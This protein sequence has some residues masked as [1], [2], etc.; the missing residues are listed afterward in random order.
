[1]K[2]IGK[3]LRCMPVLICLTLLIML[4]PSHAVMNDYCINPPFIVGGVVPNLLMMFDNSSS[5]FDLNYVDKGGA[6]RPSYYCYDQTYRTNACS[7]TTAT[8]C[9]SSSE[10]PTGQTCKNAYA[11]VFE[12][13]KF[14][15]YNF[16]IA[17]KNFEEIAAFPPA[18]CSSY[19]VANTLC[20]TIAG[21]AVT[22]FAAKG[23]YLNWLSASKFDNQ[24]KILTG[25]KYV[26]KVCA[27]H[28]TVAC[29]TDGDCI[30]GDNCPE[31]PSGGET[32]LDVNNFLQSESRGCVGRK[33]VKEP[34]TADFQEFTPANADSNSDGRDDNDPNIGLG[35]TFG[36][37]GPD[38]PF[39]RTALSLGGQTYID[40]FLGDYSQ[41]KCDDAIKLLE[42]PNAQKNDT[43]TAIEKCLGYAATNKKYCTLDQTLQCNQDTDCLV[44]P[45]TYT[46]SCTLGAGTCGLLNNGVCGVTTAGTCTAKN[47]TCSNSK[48][49]IGG[50][51]A[52]AGCNNNNACNSGV[53]SKTC[54]GGGADSKDGYA[55]NNNNACLYSVCTAG[56]M[57]LDCTSDATV[58][59]AK[60]CTNNTNGGIKLGASCTVNADCN[61]GTCTTANTK[62]GLD[63]YS[64]TQCSD[65]K[66][67]AGSAFNPNGYCESNFDCSTNKG[68]CLAPVTTQIKS[69]FAQSMHSCYQYTKKGQDI[70]TNEVQQISNP[71]GCNQMYAQYM[72]C[73]GGTNHEKQC[74]GNAGDCP[75]GT[76]IKGPDAIVPGSPV[77]VC[78]TQ[79]TGYCA[80]TNDNW[81]NTIWMPRGY[82]SADECI[83]AKYREYC[84]ALEVPPV[85]DPTDAPSASTDYQNLPAIINDIGLDAQLDLIGTL[86]VQLKK[87][88][89]P[90]GLLN[91]YSGKIRFGA[92]T[93]NSNG[94]AAECGI[95]VCSNNYTTTCSTNSDCAGTAICVDPVPCPKKC[96][97]TT[98]LACTIKPDCPPGEE[99]IATT[100]GV[101]LDNQ[102]GALIKH[103]I[104]AN[105]YCE[106]A[107]STSC[108]KD[109]DCPGTEKCISAGNHNYGLISTTDRIR[110]STWTPFT[111]AFYNAI[112]YY[113]R[114]N[115][116]SV[117]PGTSRTALRLNTG[118]FLENKNPS[119]YYCQKNNILLIT[120]GS[121]TADL[122]T[123]TVTLATR[124]VSPADRA[125]AGQVGICGNYKGSM[126]LD[127]VAWVAKH[128]DI[129]TFSPT[130]TD[131]KP[132]SAL[133]NS[134][135]I[136]TYVVFTGADNGLTGECNSFT[137]MNQTAA[138]GG[139]TS[140]KMAEDPEKL[141]NALKESFQTIASGAGS[142][143]AAS[144]LASGE[145]SG[146]NLIQALFYTT[147][148]T[149]GTTLIDPPIK[150]T[151]T[152]KNLWYYID[153][154]IGNSTIREDNAAP[155][156]YTLN[157]NK[158]KIVNFRFTGDKTVVDLYADA[159]GD[160]VKDS[161]TPSPADVP[162]EDVSSLWEAGAL[163]WNRTA[164]DRKI[165]TYDGTSL[166]ELPNTISV[167]SPLIS[168]LQAVNADEATAIAKYVK[169]EDVKVCNNSKKICTVLGDCGGTDTS[170]DAYRS[171]TV[172][173]KVWKLGDIINSTPRIA[174]WTPQNLYHKSYLDGEYRKFIES[175]D[176]G[177]RG[178]VFTGAND[179]MF[180]AFYLGQLEL[181]SEKF[182]KATLA[183]PY[184]IGIGKELWAYIPR[185][186][187]PYLRYLADKEY[188]HIY[189]AD[190]TPYIFD[191]SINSPA[192]CGGNYWDCPKQTKCGANKDCTTVINTLDM[193]NTSWRTVIIGSMRLGG[194][195][196]DPASPST[197]GVK[198][199]LAGEGFSSYF[200]LDITDNLAHPDDPSG[201]P[202]VLLWEFSD[203]S[204]GFS[205]T[206]PAVLRVAPKIGDTD[207]SGTVDGQDNADNNKN[208]RFYVVIGSGP[209]GPID[210]NQFRSYS[211]QPLKLFV[212][213][214]KTGA[215]LRTFNETDFGIKNAFAGSLVN[216][217]VDLDQNNP[218]YA[219]FY[220]D[221]AIYFGYT[222]AE[223]DP[224]TASTKWNR[225]GIMRLFTKH[226]L[227]PNLWVVSKVMND[228]LG[229]ASKDDIV[230]PVTAAVNRLQ[231]YTK[232]T[233]R[234]FFG[235]GRYS[236]KISSDI[237]D[238][239]PKDSSN[240]DIPRRLFGVIEPCFDTISGAIDFTCSSTVSIGSLSE[241]ANA[242]G[243]SDADGWYINLDICTKENPA[244]HI[245][246]NV[247]CTSTDEGVYKAERSVTDIAA[248]PMGAVFFTTTK[249]SAD[250]CAFGGGT[251]LWAVQYDTGGEVKSGV[252]RGKAIV[253]VSTGEI[254]EVDLKVAFTEKG[255]RRTDVIPGVPPAGPPPGLIVPPQPTNKVI[256]IRER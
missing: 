72:T 236:Y 51:N 145:G 118:D 39:N 186:A 154:F 179:G 127:D 84:G 99:C 188:C 183:D 147:R 80:D 56:N 228:P 222:K 153:P 3:F 229:A 23:N 224:L 161:A 191:A 82:A 7:T 11:G 13:N 81:Q 144:V 21:S 158:D 169:G 34:N 243:T 41:M 135:M 90:T 198:T 97:L 163:L 252:L 211:D 100:K 4:S 96:S 175:D 75:G 212:L 201:H 250:V 112:G 66:C 210:T 207:L 71:S 94:T 190:A 40:V 238:D 165:C 237:D 32:C 156:D 220:Q 17:K 70:G 120:D 231:N 143:T 219:G 134:E 213:D 217:M 106:A 247:A 92:M 256:H 239:N 111:E 157:I 113:A 200:A 126:N 16:D 203:P 146:A 107:T 193:A 139:T 86:V 215:L 140:A 12:V 131:P 248:T 54:T 185:N 151:G 22:A 232:K 189:Y 101:Y 95:K 246:T 178:L 225:G 119:Q 122:Q 251:H 133:K 36:V 129:K 170:C 43:Q 245:T 235:S 78:S 172:D 182:K 205:T 87:D 52:G 20:A 138:N 226:E 168:L 27:F 197:L 255:G 15:N 67:T 65:S 30:G 8:K 253:Q 88:T 167:G 35:I 130:S 38:H 152:L 110:A 187:L 199:P 14:Y 85:V 132:A 208:G 50:T 230:G 44:P 227:D 28:P 37:K 48:S 192:G 60:T 159:N 249:P 91:D 137:M 160:G 218:S 63:C 2:T 194:G 76:C 174:S 26:D 115:A 204:L 209:T 123:D 117:S 155:K 49:C 25:G 162:F 24:K 108:L 58:C 180:H 242:L 149:F 121:S 195:C 173:S 1:M 177:K 128:R 19:L 93:F 77:L 73:N 62:F 9:A 103:Y 214:L 181:F 6:T 109:S 223:E 244:T 233:L 221:D 166:I 142:G 114:T 98:S 102:D 254:R 164:S 141:Y 83:K 53:C 61:T 47:G 33:F 31:C 116:Y 68:R 240:N 5:M 171:R 216:S 57:G 89:A 18:G 206:G 29:T 136:D 64:N 45:G 59:S 55:C 74:Y 148:D 176:Y 104:G 125:P 10:C 69:T 105:G 196:K 124:Y 150:W 42:D 202:P 241:A 79:Y 234:L 184:G 46:G